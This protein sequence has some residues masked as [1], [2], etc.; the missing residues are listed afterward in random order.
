MSNL[1]DRTNPSVLADYAR[2]LH[3][4]ASNME[5][6]A[7]QIDETER[8]RMS[9][10]PLDERMD[11][12]SNVARTTYGSRFQQKHEL[13]VIRDTSAVHVWRNL[14]N[15]LAARLTNVKGVRS[16][17]SRTS[18]VTQQF[19]GGD[20][21]TPTIALFVMF[22]QSGPISFDIDLT[23]KDIKHYWKTVEN[24]Y[25][26]ILHRG[27]TFVE[28]HM[29]AQ[30]QNVTFQMGLSTSET[31]YPPQTPYPPHITNFVKFLNEALD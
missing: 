10:Y 24:V 9:V 28:T 11:E 14:E 1:Q 8:N 21:A 22:M 5:Q 12:G 20:N 18:N 13:L 27:T 29:S 3:E 4:M 15:E 16:A 31:P 6:L 19:V 30:T 23:I 7:T 25:V 26:L 17:S 2:K